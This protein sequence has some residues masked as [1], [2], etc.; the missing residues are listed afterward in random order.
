MT[1]HT[2]STGIR[3]GGGALIAANACGTATMRAIR[4]TVLGRPEVL[5]HPDAPRPR[6][7]PTE[8]LV[9]VTAAGVDPLDWKTRS[10]GVFH[11]SALHPWEPTWLVSSKP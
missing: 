9:R 7:R 3:R 10:R 2:A 5:E 8:V 1:S 6:P 11:G 4:Q